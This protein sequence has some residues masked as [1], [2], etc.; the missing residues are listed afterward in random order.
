MTLHNIFNHFES[1][2]LDFYLFEKKQKYI[3]EL[4]L[5]Q[6]NRSHKIIYS[7]I[8]IFYMIILFLYGIL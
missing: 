2:F 8:F 4:H 5:P 1:L 3:L 7:Y 6:F